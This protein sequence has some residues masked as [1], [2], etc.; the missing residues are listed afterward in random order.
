MKKSFTTGNIARICRVTINTV[1][2]WFDSGEL[3]GYR[4]PSSRARRVK[5]KD[6]LAFMKKHDFPMD[7]IAAEK[8]KIL[9]VDSDGKTYTS[10][11]KTLSKDDR[12]LLENATSGFEAGLQTGDSAPDMI[13]LNIDLSDVDWRRV[14]AL[15]G[16]NKD[17]ADITLMAMS[18]KIRKKEAGELEKLGYAGALRKPRR[19]AA[20]RELLGKYTP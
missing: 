18:R 5:R 15:L 7:R 17:T 8:F 1:V 19:P 16:K 4:I 11:L 9:I 2:K 12:Y 13:F 14:G 20:L 10:F 3:K 6:L